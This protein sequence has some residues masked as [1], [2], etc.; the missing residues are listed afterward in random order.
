[1]MH[2]ATADHRST[3][4]S[5]CQATWQLLTP[6]TAGG[7]A[8]AIIQI[9]GNIDA[10]LQAMAQSALSGGSF[11]VRN[12]AGIDRAVLARWSDTCLHL[13]PH[14]GTAVLHE[15]GQWL[16]YSGI[17][18]TDHTL[19]LADLRHAYPEATSDVQALMLW[20]LS[21]AASPAAVDLLLAQPAL[22]EHRDW[23]QPRTSDESH[24]DSVLMRLIHPPL[25]VIVG[26][27]NV[28]KSRLLNALAGHTVSIVSD[29]AGTT[30]D[31]VG[32]L[33]LCDNV[34]VRLVDTPGARFTTDAIEAH[35]QAISRRLIQHADLVLS[36][37]DGAH[38]F[39]DGLDLSAG[40][41]VLRVGTKFDIY[42]NHPRAD[43]TISAATGHGLPELA[44]AISQMLIPA[45]ARQ[46]PSPWRFWEGLDTQS[47]APTH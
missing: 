42:G 11:Q 15:L 37:S 6:N 34:A 25:V 33:A 8:I 40:T 3:C 23:S 19:S 30:R 20:T 29:Q 43:L 27:P 32:V 36:C 18:K 13:M 2:A 24:R 47:P 28:G 5:T 21:R 17:I 45:Q 4:P 22:W 9:T 1:M 35:A 38:P 7:A 39:V 14:G 46:S 16:E 31:H 26:E 12:L 41:R 44:A 10:A